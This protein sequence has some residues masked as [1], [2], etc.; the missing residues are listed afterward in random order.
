VGGIPGR[1][2]YDVH[3]IE[4]RVAGAIADQSSAQES[5]AEPTV[6]DLNVNGSRG[7]GLN[8]VQEANPHEG[9]WRSPRGGSNLAPDGAASELDYLRFR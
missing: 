9:A 3:S 5:G 6:N 2:E 1:L 7:V 4:V 8:H